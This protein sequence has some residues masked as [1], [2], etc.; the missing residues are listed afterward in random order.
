MSKLSDKFNNW[1][2]KYIEKLLNKVLDFIDMPFVEDPLDNGNSEPITT[3]PQPTQPEQ[4]IEPTQ[5]EKT[6]DEVAYKDLNF[7]WG[8]FKKKDAYIVSLIEKL[9]VNKNGLSYKWKSGGCEHMGASSKTDAGATLAC[10]FCKIGGKWVGGKNDWVSSSRTTRDFKNIREGYNGWSKTAIEDAS[11]YAFC[12]VSYKNNTRTNVIKCSKIFKSQSTTS[13]IIGIVKQ[14]LSFFIGKSEKSAEKKDKI[15]KQIEEQNEELKKA[16]SEGRISDAGS[17]SSTISKL[18]KKFNK[19][20][21]FSVLALCLMLSGCKTAK[22]AP[23]YNPPLVLGERVFIC[24]EK[25]IIEIPTLVPPATK[26]Y[27]VDNIGL[28]QWLGIPANQQP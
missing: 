19:V 12:I 5:S 9:S 4:T 20:G 18:Y 10:L 7:C 17:I 28:T 16:L 22:L 6:D 27:L 21:L 1:L 23:E 3:D 2:N 14:V 26:W 15:M 24:K 13:D 11:E 25:D 8:G